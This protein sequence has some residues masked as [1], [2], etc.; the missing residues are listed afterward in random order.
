MENTKK[1]L[2]SI[3][4]QVIVCSLGSLVLPQEVNAC[5]KFS[6]TNV[7]QPT[8]LD[9]Q[10][11]KLCLPV[12][13]RLLHPGRLGELENPRCISNLYHLATREFTTL[14]KVAN[15]DNFRALNSAQTYYSDGVFMYVYMLRPHPEP[16]YYLPLADVEL[17][18]QQPNWFVFQG[19]L[20]HHGDKVLI[21]EA[22]TYKF[23]H[24]ITS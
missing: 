15:E 7:D 18:G 9:W 19:I 8:L 10:H 22:Q 2:I 14:D 24:S 21:L 11:E 23:Y 6:S 17:I 1:S 12:K 3:F 5:E 13:S 20:Y 4:L 16:F